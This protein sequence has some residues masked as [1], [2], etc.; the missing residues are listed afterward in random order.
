L[1]GSVIF[2]CKGGA[3]RIRALCG[4]RLHEAR[5]SVVAQHRARRLDEILCCDERERRGS[6]HMSAKRVVMMASRESVEGMRR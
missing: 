1:C 5:M 3:R 2:V 6:R 4:V